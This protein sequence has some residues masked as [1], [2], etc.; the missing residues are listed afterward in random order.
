MLKAVPNNDYNNAHDFFCAR[1]QDK[2]R[3]G[4]ESR[5]IGPSSP[6]SSKI[7]GPL[8]KMMIRSTGSPNQNPAHTVAKLQFSFFHN[9]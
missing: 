6:P 7:H 1:N 5:L 2:D 9:S 3:R 4:R 8:S